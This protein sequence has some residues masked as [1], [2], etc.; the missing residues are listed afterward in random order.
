MASEATEAER[1]V[2]VAALLPEEVVGSSLADTG[3]LLARASE[4]SAEAVVGLVT[5]TVTVL[6]LVEVTVTVDSGPL[7]AE[8]TAVPCAD[9]VETLK[10][11]PPRCTS[12]SSGVTLLV[13]S[14]TAPDATCCM[15]PIAS[16]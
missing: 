10:T 1:P 15:L 9:S 12:L 14:V 4:G 6:L 3:L 16:S 8:V 7:G 5:V 2:P 11:W 13:E